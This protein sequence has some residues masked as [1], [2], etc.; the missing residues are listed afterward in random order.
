MLFNKIIYCLYSV[1]VGGAH[2]EARLSLNQ[3][4][5]VLNEGL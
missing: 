2:D 4:K 5:G 1:L 3:L